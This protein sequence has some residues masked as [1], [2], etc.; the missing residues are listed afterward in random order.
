MNGVFSLIRF[1]EHAKIRL[2]T[3]DTPL[4]GVVC[5]TD[6]ILFFLNIICD[7][8]FGK[9][10]TNLYR[11]ERRDFGRGNSFQ[12]YFFEK[13]EEVVVFGDVFSPSI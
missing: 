9:N 13:E 7:F 12:R 11:E 2:R 10:L 3:H 5:E 4:Q 8:L 6:L 1:H